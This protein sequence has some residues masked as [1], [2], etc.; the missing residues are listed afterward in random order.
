MGVSKQCNV[1]RFLVLK[2]FLELC[3]LFICI[4]GFFGVVI[5]LLVFSS[6]SRW[7]THKPHGSTRHPDLGNG[8]KY[9]VI[10]QNI[11]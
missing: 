1:Q 10:A 3:V 9:V 6:S 5:I 4:E 8:N 11:I 2:S 7:T